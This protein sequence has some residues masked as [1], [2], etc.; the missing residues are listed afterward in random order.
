MEAKALQR[1]VLNQLRSR[2]VH[3]VDFQALTWVEQNVRPVRRVMDVGAN[4]GQTIVSVRLVLG[5]AVEIHSFEANPALWP[6]LERVAKASGGSVHVH[7]FGL[8]AEDGEMVLHVPSVDGVSYL[9]ESTLDL[10]QFEKP[11]VKDKYEQRG[12]TT[13]FQQVRVPIRRG[14]DFSLAPD[15]IKIDV[16]GFES[17]AVR[18]LLE[19]IRQHRPVL[20]VENNDYH[21]VTELLSGFDYRPCAWHGDTMRV[22]SEATTNTFYLPLE[23][24]LPP[25][26]PEH[27][28]MSVQTDTETSGSGYQESADM[29]FHRQE[30]D[31]MFELLAVEKISLDASMR[32]LDVG[33]GA[34]I[35]SGFL[36]TMVDRVVCMDF[37]DQEK[38]YDGQLV[39]LMAE[40]FQRN[41]HGFDVGRFEFHQGDAMNLMYRDD[42][43]DAIVS[44]NAFEHIPDPELALREMLRVVKPGGHIYLTF[45]P[46]WTCDSGSHFY[47]R[48]PRPWEHLLTDDETF[49]AMMREAGASD[50]EVEDYRYAMNRRRLGYYRDL[51]ARMRSEMQMLQEHEWAG[52]SAEDNPSHENYARCLAAGFSK[53]ELM[54]R[55]MV[56]LIRKPLRS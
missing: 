38:R 36:S 32:V 2:L 54:T 35:H 53:D 1:V 52:C 34:G 18:G 33:G 28:A 5:K 19:T 46:I 23:V 14:D 12:H 16:E 31:R 8:G 27:D 39:K 11:W 45:D 42:W 3:D 24:E 20:M 29:A 55:G 56:K 44:F 4:V 13:E 51:F 6:G 21:R 41:G 30:V 22:M 7:R 9:E 25:P 50:E 37:I 48:I 15:L 10:G 49:V 26:P 43:F 17:E 47:Y 40:K